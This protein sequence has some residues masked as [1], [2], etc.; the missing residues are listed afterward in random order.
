MEPTPLI[1]FLIEKSIYAVIIAVFLGFIVIFNFIYLKVVM[2]F[3]GLEGSFLRVFSI[4][5]ISSLCSLLPDDLEAVEQIQ[6]QHLLE[7][8]QYRSLD[9]NLDRNL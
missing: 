9:R 4:C 2:R 1:P 3:V 7:A 8:I 5:F 6:P